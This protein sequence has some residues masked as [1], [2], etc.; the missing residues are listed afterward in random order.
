MYKRWNELWGI[1]SYMSSSLIPA[2]VPMKLTD[3]TTQHLKNYVYSAKCAQELSKLDQDNLKLKI[4]QW[5]SENPTTMFY[6]RPHKEIKHEKTDSTST[7]K[8]DPVAFSQTLLY[9]HQEKW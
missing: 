9:V 2:I 8:V 1:V 4:E 3:H 7:D 6:Y 5:K